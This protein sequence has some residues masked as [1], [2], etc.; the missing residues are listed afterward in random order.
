M[1]SRVTLLPGLPF[2]LLAENHLPI[3]NGRDLQIGGSQVKADPAA[4]EVAAEVVFP[5]VLRGN[6]LGR[7]V[8]DGEITLIDSFAEEVNVESPFAPGCIYRPPGSTGKANQPR[9]AS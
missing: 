3:D 2:D 1:V 5:F 8:H 9:S 7:S 4:A 6:V